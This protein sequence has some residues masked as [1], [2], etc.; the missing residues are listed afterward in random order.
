MALIV[1]FNY[2]RI[3]VLSLL[4]YPKANWQ[5]KMEC[6]FPIQLQLFNFVLTN[7]PDVKK[8]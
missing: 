3:E 4:P 6:L 5:Q 8:W 7:I 2:V 1:I